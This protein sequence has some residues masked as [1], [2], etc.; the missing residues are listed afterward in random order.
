MNLVCC[1]SLFPEKASRTNGMRDCLAG[2][3][4]GIDAASQPRG[5]LQQ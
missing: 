5:D 4:F 1:T 2:G 3:S